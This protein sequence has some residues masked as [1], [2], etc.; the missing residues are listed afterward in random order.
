MR[1]IHKSKFYSRAFKSIFLNKIKETELLPYND[2]WR[3]KILHISGGIN[4]G[5]PQRFK[6]YVDGFKSIAQDVYLGSKIET[7]SKG[8]LSMDEVVPIADQVNAGL[9][10]NIFFILV[11]GF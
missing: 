10:R 1:V 8:T 9:T 11:A 2:L 3:K 5:E 7:K 4:P 6:N